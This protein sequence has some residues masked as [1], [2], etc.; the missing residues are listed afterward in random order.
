MYKA[1][2]LQCTCSGCPSQW[3]I[4]CLDEAGDEIY[5]LAHYRHGIFTLQ[6]SGE[7]DDLIFK[8]F[9]DAYGGVMNEKKMKKLCAAVIDFSEVKVLAE[10]F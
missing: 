4:K 8:D 1:Q 7:R 6:E 10:E 9:N 2:T 5:F 3:N